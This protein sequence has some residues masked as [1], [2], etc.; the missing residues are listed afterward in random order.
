MKHPSTAAAALAP[1]RRNRFFEESV[2]FQRP[3]MTV[4]AAGIA[5]VAVFYLIILLVGMLAA[6]KQR[7]AGRGTASPEESIMLAKRDLGLFVGVLTMTGKSLI[8]LI[9]HSICSILSFQV[10]STVVCCCE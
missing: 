7:K 1:R 8:S 5:A 3:V 4:N 9:P 10:Y 2:A 6:W